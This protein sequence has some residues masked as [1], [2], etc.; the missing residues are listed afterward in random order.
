[1]SNK[2]DEYYSILIDLAYLHQSIVEFAKRPKIHHGG[3][4]AWINLEKDADDFTL[5]DLAK[6][7]QFNVSIHNT[8]EDVFKAIDPQE[9]EK[10]V[11]LQ[12]CG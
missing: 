10:V 4:G 11:G 1:M 9:D 12:K 7:L 2:M 3:D 5:S 8:F 6:S